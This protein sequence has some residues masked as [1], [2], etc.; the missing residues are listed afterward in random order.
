M[1]P[2]VTSTD[3]RERICKRGRGH[4]LI[5][6]LNFVDSTTEP[7]HS[8][9]SCFDAVTSPMEQRYIHSAILVHRSRGDNKVPDSILRTQGAL[10]PLGFYAQTTT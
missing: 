4:I 6:R 3:P 10:P 7:T 1:T 5:P 8:S 2:G 9:A